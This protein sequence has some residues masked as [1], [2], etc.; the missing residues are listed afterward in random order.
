MRL[1]IC[2]VGRMRA[3]PERTLLAD[4]LTRFERAGRPLSL[5]P[6]V[7]HEIDERKANTVET[8]GAALLRPVAEGAI[9]AA[10]DER[11]KQLSSPQF[12]NWLAQM[13]DRG[14]GDLAFVIGGAD[15]LAPEVTSRADMM[16]SLGQM[17]WPHKLVRVMLA[18]Q[19]YRAA[20]IL[21]GSPYHRT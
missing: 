2:A 7:E 9:V 5:G 14:A 17:V 18:E 3:G 10:L 19:V 15:G 4:Y 6:A 20:T 12:A 1:H 21:A 16:I 13:R 11:G 8:Q